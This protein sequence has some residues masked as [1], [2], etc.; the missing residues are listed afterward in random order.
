MQFYG[1]YL[2]Q[3]HSEYSTIL[4]RG[5]LF[6]EFLVDAWA[7][8]EQSRLNFMRFNQIKLRVDKYASII[9][10]KDAGLTPEEG[11]TPCILPSSYI[12]SPRYM[13]EIYQDKMASTPFNHHPDI[14]LTM[15]ANPNWTEIQD[16][17]LQ[18]QYACHRQLSR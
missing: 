11:S 12:R 9:E 13:Y 8:T 7:S 14:F 6:Q 1:Y 15:T 4:R 2:F 10:M 18:H 16:E 3:R 17:L 5:K